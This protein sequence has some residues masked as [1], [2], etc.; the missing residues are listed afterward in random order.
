MIYDRV[1]AVGVNNQRP[2]PAD[3][4]PQPAPAND[5]PRPANQQNVIEEE[6][7]PPEIQEILNLAPLGQRIVNLL[8]ESLRENEYCLDFV[9]KYKFGH[10]NAIMWA[11]AQEMRPNFATNNIGMVWFNVGRIFAAELHAYAKLITTN[12]CRFYP[13]LDHCT[14]RLFLKRFGPANKKL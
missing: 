10:N 4:N 1:E 6:P 3:D 5:N 2:A 12:F 11:P 13:Q 7:N 9:R 14:V 8:Q